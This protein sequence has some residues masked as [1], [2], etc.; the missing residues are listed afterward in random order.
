MVA[1]VFEMKL[2]PLERI[3][4][5]SHSKIDEAWLQEP[6]ANNPSILGLGDLELHDRER[7]QIVCCLPSTTP[8]VLPQQNHPYG[9]EG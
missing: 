3:K 1:E 2:V 8:L 9:L 7:R 4:L 6:I 5:K